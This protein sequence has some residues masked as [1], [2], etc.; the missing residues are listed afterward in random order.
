MNNGQQKTKLRVLVEQYERGLIAQKLHD[1]NGD[2]AA[3]AKELRLDRG[4][5]SRLIRKY[6]LTGTAYDLNATDG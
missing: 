3:V 2:R 4:N 5:L 1:H 6:K